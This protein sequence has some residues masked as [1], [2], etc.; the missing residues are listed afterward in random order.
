VGEN[1]MKVW[2][3]YYTTCDLK[4]PHYHFAAK[5]M[6][7]YPDD[8]VFTGPVWLYVGKTPIFALPFM[9]NSISHGR[10]SGFLRPDIEFGLT[11][12]KS[13]FI[14]NLGY[15]WATNDYTD[16]T[17]I[18]DFDEDV[19]W[20][21]Y[22]GNRYALRYRFN[23]DVNYNY[24]RDVDGKGSEWTLDAGHA[25]T[26]GERFTLNA[27]LRFV[28]S[29]AAPQ[30]V[31]TIDNVNRYIDRSLHSNVSLR[32]SWSASAIS[33]SGSRVQN[34]NITDTEAPKITMTAP[35]IQLSI[36]SRNLYFGSDVG[37]AHGFLQNLLKNT[38]YSP[39]LSGNFVR[40]EKEFET[41]DVTTASAG[42]NLQSPQRIGFLTVSPAASANLVSTRYSDNVVAH[43][44]TVI[45]SNP[46]DTTLIPVAAF[47]SLSTH[48]DFRW[49][50]GGNTTTNFYGTFY[51]HI[52]RLRGIRHAVTPSV[53]YAYSPGRDGGPRNQ[54]VSMNLRNALDL[55]VAGRD[56]T[57][58][59]QEDVHKLSGVV[60][61]SLSSQYRP[62]TPVETAWSNISSAV[63]F[64]LFG[65]NLSLNHTVDP[66]TLQILN[67][68]ATSDFHFGGSHPFGRTQKLKVEE[69]N[70]VA[71]ED[72]TKRDKSG[73]G[74]AY[75]QRDQYGKKQEKT[76]KELDLKEGRLP[77]NLNLGLSYSKSQTGQVSSTMRVGWDIQLTDKW[78]I[79]Y[80]TIYDVESRSLEGQNFGITRDLHCWEMSFSRQVLGNGP[81]EEWQY[82][83]RITLKAHPD[84]YGESGTRGLG[85]GLMG[86][87]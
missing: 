63:N 7:V 4:N 38:R 66:Y 65:L 76:R 81:N 78:R 39:S 67:T 20:R 56:T 9:A 84:L 86:Q 6:K 2:D 62:D 55:K 17:F 25:Q 12:N 74:V 61:W 51:P 64:N 60:I 87:F 54:S 41:T 19:R 47:D 57:S 8:K 53:S 49:N 45:S 10:R 68:S 31:N 77:W 22:I 1:E 28:S 29:D 18:A 40:T 52:G 80:S 14:R 70:E 26:L 34:L 69:L 46:P 43:N 37:A 3:S 30:S 82:Y 50:F 42:L 15:Y 24:V 83:F 21:L 59:G 35:D 36:P 32:K 58:T 75:E 73:S 23:G 79:D 16:F 71:A 33:V 85:T 13:R 48:H 72:T 11:S 44:R 5:N 27:N